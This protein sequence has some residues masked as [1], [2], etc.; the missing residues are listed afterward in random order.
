ML[1]S[2][3][4]A[5]FVGKLVGAICGIVGVAVIVWAQLQKPKSVEPVSL[6][7][8]RRS[9]NVTTRDWIGEWG[10]SRRD[11]NQL[12]QSDV[13]A[14]FVGGTCAIRSDHMPLVR[15][16]VAAASEL[17]GSRLFHSPG[18]TLSHAIQSQTEHW[19]RWLYFL[20]ETEGLNRKVSVRGSD[21]DGY[22][23][24]LAH[25]SALACQKCAAKS[26]S[27]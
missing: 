27:V 16:Q 5:V 25:V 12:E 3:A 21:D 22:I 1:V 8:S 15:D 18:I 13:F 26:L 23:E 4:L 20:K 19:K 14:E 6:A 24:G 10:E 9:E 7:R 17:A 11:F 2:V